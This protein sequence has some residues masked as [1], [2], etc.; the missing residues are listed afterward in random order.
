MEITPSQAQPPARSELR[1]GIL[2]GKDRI[3]R[4]DRECRYA[5]RLRDQGILG[6][7]PVR[8]ETLGRFRFKEYGKSYSGSVSN[9]L[10]RL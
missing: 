3:S 1:G 5:P 6:S 10:A 9:S 7:S 8:T 2:V 4:E